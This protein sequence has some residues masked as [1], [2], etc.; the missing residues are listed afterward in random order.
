MDSVSST[1]HLAPSTS[2]TSTTPSSI[3]PLRPSAFGAIS[4]PPLL[5]LSLSTPPKKSAKNGIQFS[6]GS[7]DR[8]QTNSMGVGGE[9]EQKMVGPSPSKKMRRA[10]PGLRGANGKASALEFNI[11]AR[12][13]RARASVLRLPHYDCRTPM[14]MP[15]GTNGSVKGLTPQQLRE[16]RL[17]YR[18]G[19]HRSQC[20]MLTF[21]SFTF[22]PQKYKH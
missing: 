12:Q 7:A 10:D 19:C 14:F 8:D 5:S 22:P 11:L 21:F 4:P 15:V 1:K 6:P 13:G 18:S 2:L 20:A 3:A 16:V 9:D 17:R